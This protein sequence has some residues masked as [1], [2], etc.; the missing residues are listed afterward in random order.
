M[1]LNIL[2]N[3]NSTSEDFLNAQVGHAIAEHRKGRAVILTRSNLKRLFGV[4][5]SAILDV[6]G[7]YRLANLENAMAGL[8]KA[9]A[10]NLRRNVESLTISDHEI[11]GPSSES[12]Q[13]G[14]VFPHAVRRLAA[15]S[16]N[17]VTAAP[18]FYIG[19]TNY[20][21]FFARE[22]QDLLLKNRWRPMGRKDRADMAK[23][24]RRWP[25]VISELHSNFPN[26]E[27]TVWRNETFNGVL[28]TL[29]ADILNV[30]DVMISAG[31][32]NGQS[33]DA[34]RSDRCDRTGVKRASRARRVQKLPGSG[35][36]RKRRL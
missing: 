22:H 33:P 21:D 30:D 31:H 15:F 11:F 17:W 5:F 32:A 18:D 28:P 29:L 6:N 19:L 16:P 36:F 3:S 4:S 24:V 35:K 10:R 34:P 26:S 25:D 27:I 20:A 14:E 7:T 13:L 1:K 8:D 23:M 12:I 9:L 2:V